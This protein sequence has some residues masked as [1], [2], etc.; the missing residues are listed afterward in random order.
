MYGTKRKERLEDGRVKGAIL[1]AHLDWARQNIGSDAVE[2]IAERIPG[3]LSPQLTE[4]V[5]ASQWIP[6]S[7]LIETDRAIAALCGKTQS[8]TFRLLGR[9]SA[10]LNLTTTYR[11]FLR[12]DI[13]K[14]LKHEA[15][16]R[17]QFVDFGEATVEKKEDRH[18]AITI[19]RTR[20]FSP[21]FCES[22]VGYYEAACELLGAR[23]VIVRHTACLC[24]GED[25]CVFD[26][27][28]SK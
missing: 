19:S 5:L 6:F 7:L 3:E 1:L 21:V 11:A 17:K 8:A 10:K 2:L 14:F 27:V 12:T 18:F 13:E 20:T 23:D 25:T 26:I 22:A 15:L 4:G 24:R 28:W 9:H 16:Q